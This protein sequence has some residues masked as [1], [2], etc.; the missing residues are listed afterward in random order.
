MMQFQF[1]FVH[2]IGL[3]TACSA[4]SERQRTNQKD[5]EPIVYEMNYVRIL[6]K[7]LFCV[8]GL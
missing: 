7:M 1:L 2:Q 8:G 5:K 6:K 4:L 3:I